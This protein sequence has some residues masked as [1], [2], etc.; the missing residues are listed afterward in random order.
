MSGQE[1]KAV[2]DSLGLGPETVAVEAGVGIATLYRVY[3]EK[4]V[5]PKTRAKVVRALER[6]SAKQAK[7]A[8]ASRAI[9]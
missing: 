9:A 5:S 1:L 8:G 7:L 4:V 6:L 3:N 2:M